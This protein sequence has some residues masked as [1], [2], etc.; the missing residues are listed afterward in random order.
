[1]YATFPGLNLKGGAPN[2]QDVKA[3]RLLIENLKTD[4]SRFG[5]SSVSNLIYV[6]SPATK[7]DI[8]SSALG[9]VSIPISYSRLWDYSVNRAQG[10]SRVL[11]HSH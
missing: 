11:F 8:H 4:T 2:S 7:V 5:A 1:M 9:T 3:W 10:R 6:Q